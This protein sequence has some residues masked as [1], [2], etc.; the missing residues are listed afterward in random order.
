MICHWSNVYLLLEAPIYLTWLSLI[1]SSVDIVDNL[2][3]TDHDCVELHLNIL[4]PKQSSVQYWSRHSLLYK[5]HGS[6]SCGPRKRGMR[7]Q[8]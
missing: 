3:T 7:K 2:P 5:T 8:E 1:V 6:V 4:P